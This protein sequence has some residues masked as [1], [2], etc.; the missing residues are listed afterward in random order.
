MVNA[1]TRVNYSHDHNTREVMQ[2]L[3]HSNSGRGQTRSYLA[4]RYNI[5]FIGNELNNC[6]VHVTDINVAC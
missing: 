3:R 4:W 6:R 2:K 1:E 5:A